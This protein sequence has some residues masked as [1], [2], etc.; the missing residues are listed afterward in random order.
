[1]AWSTLI[2]PPPLAPQPH[3]TRKCQLLG[4]AARGGGLRAKQVIGQGNDPTLVVFRNVL[5]LPFVRP[6]GDVHEY[7]AQPF[8]DSTTGDLPGPGLP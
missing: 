6:L 5:P 2:R 8:P 4:W 3:L 7:S 1:M